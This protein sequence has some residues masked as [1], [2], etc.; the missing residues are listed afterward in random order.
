MGLFDFLFGK[1]ELI[2]TLDVYIEALTRAAGDRRNPQ[3]IAR[4]VRTWG[5]EIL[6]TYGL[7]GINHAWRAVTQSADSEDL[8]EVIRREWGGIPGWKP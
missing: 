2:W 5:E 8:V 6:D 3:E 4:K 1:H 7:V